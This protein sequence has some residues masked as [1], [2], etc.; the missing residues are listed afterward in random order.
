[1]RFTGIGLAAA[2]VVAA[3]TPAAAMAAK[4]PEAPA[5]G[6]DAKARERGMAETPALITAA[7]LACTV[8]DA[9]F[10][11]EDKKAG[12]AFYEVACSP[13][14]GGVLM[15]KT[16]AKPQF[17]TC[18]ETSKPAADG[19]PN[20]LACK[21][22]GNADPI[23]AL[24]PLVAKSGA[25][26][27]LEKARS[28]GANNTNSFFEI[29]C[30]GG[31]GYILQTSNP[32]SPTGEVKANTCL[33][34]EPG[35]N[36]SCELTD[37]ATQLAVVDTLAAGS[38]KSCAVKDK[39]YVLSTATANWFEVSCQ[40]GKGYMLEQAN[41]GKLARA[42]DCANASFVGGGCT[43]TD[44]SVAQT[45]QNNLYTNLATKAGFKCK[46]EKYGIM[47]SQRASQEIVELKCSDRPDGAVAIFDGAQNT[48]LNCAV[49]E[50]Q[51]FRCSFTKKDVAYPKLTA[52]LKTLGKG[53]CVVSDSR[54][55]DKRT[56]D[57]NYLEVACS[58]GLPG[59]VIGYAPMTD[60]PKEVLSCLQAENLGA[61]KLPTNKRKK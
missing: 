32:V 26:C 34:Y 61:C 35:G 36:L 13:G 1:M 9:R 41:D 3:M 6:V 46:V 53:D 52:D 24:A 40:D 5:G 31:S 51:G 4:K 10:I 14:L 27:T 30:Q 39:R 8:A 22:P 49:S 50:A 37:R 48:F 7:G 55:M 20:S 33:A 25:A 21:L 28:I 60:K 56:A 38:G 44:S 59:W 19:K 16:E 12:Q 42:I 58:D 2:L 15:A 17:F 45:E 23:Q 43:L 57:A 47:P 54:A 29:A 18:L 11:G